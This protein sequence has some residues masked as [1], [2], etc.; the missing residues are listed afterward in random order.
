MAKTKSP[1]PPEFRLQMV[2]GL[3]PPYAGGAC[4]RSLN[5]RRNRSGTGSRSLSAM[6]AGATVA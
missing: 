2:Q 1:Y 3:A 4:I 5:R 6:L